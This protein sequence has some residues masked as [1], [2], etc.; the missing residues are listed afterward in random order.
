MSIISWAPTSHAAGGEWR[1][2][3]PRV[4]WDIL[5]ALREAA[6]QYGIPE[7]HD[8]NTGDNEGVCYFHVNQKRGRRWSAARGFLKP[9]LHRQNLRLETGCLV[10]GLEFDGKRASR[11]AL[12][13]ERRAAQ[14]RAAAAR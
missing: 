11:R 3:A 12:A 5:D 4:A 8:F 10:E 9:V 2:E 14:R 1:V 7:V 13:A 6:V